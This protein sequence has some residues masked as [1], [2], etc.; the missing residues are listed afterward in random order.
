LDWNDNR[1][2][3]SGA[4]EAENAG[5]FDS[6]LNSMLRQKAGA[7]NLDASLRMTLFLFVGWIV[8]VPAENRALRA[9]SRVS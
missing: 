6:L 1:G 8:V 3:R 5:P 4:D 9:K 2:A 7:T